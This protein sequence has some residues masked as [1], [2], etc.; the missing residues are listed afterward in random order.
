[1]ENGLQSVLRLIQMWLGGPRVRPQTNYTK[2]PQLTPKNNPKNL[3]TL[4]S[5]ESGKLK[6][7]NVIKRIIN[8]SRVPQFPREQHFSACQTKTCQET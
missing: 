4:H 3:Q 5:L 1:M 6:I 7:N 2:K 8:S